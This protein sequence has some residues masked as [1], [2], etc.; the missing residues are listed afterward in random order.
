VVGLLAA[1]VA[2]AK[3]VA[4]A[5]VLP[6]SALTLSALQS[7]AASII[8]LPGLLPAAGMAAACLLLYNKLQQ[9]R[10]KFFYEDWV[11]AHKH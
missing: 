3:I 1:V 9:F 11:L 10:H 7:A 8:H 2:V 6:A 4:I 5:P